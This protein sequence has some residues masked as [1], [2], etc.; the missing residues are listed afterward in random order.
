MKLT[1]IGTGYV[2]PRKLEILKSGG[3]PIYRSGL[4]EMVRR[5]VEAGGCSS[6]P[7]SGNRCLAARSRR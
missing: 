5:N 4:Q 3:I 2:D 7:I 6:L 1:V